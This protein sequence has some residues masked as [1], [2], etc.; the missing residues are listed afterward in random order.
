MSI[1]VIDEEII[2]ECISKELIYV[3]ADGEVCQEDS[4]N[5]Q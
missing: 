3:S 2:N 1:P 5:P 4:V